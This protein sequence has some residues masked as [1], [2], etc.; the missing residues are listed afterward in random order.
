MYRYSRAGGHVTLPCNTVLGPACSTV[1]WVYHR[2]TLSPTVFIVSNGK[3]LDLGFRRNSDCSLTVLRVSEEHSGRFICSLGISAKT[4]THVYLSVLTV[5]PSPPVSAQHGSIRLLCALRRYSELSCFDGT[6]H[7]LDQD[8]KDLSGTTQSC[9]SSVR[10]DL[11]SPRSRTFTCQYQDRGEVLVF[12]E[13]S[14]RSVQPH[15]GEIL[16]DMTTQSTTTRRNVVESETTEV[17]PQAVYSYKF[18]RAG[19][20]V[21]LSCDRLKHQGPSCSSVDWLY[22]KDGSKSDIK[23][24]KGQSED[25]RLRMNSNCSVTVQNV[26]AEDAGLFRCR[27]SGRQDSD[28]VVF[29]SVLTVSR[30]P[31]DPNQN[32]I[33]LQCKLWRNSR[34]DCSGGG[35]YWLDQDKKILSVRENV[36]ESSLMVDLQKTHSRNLTCQYHDQGWRL[37]LVSAEF[38]LKSE[39]V[40]NPTT[41]PGKA[42]DTLCYMCRTDQTNTAS[43]HHSVAVLV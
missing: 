20:D 6:F 23:V 42:P 36:C 10:V 28:T 31:P 29:L 2:T 30:S 26:S 43:A 12:A 14:L 9:E 33:T 8:R 25:P 34:H 27:L 4:E 11:Q 15:G 21:T 32:N 35:F 16:T 37:L 5:C 38:N 1:D 7:W 17:S 41:A 24:S 18:F 13:Y 22:D 19:E 39:R 3:S 40:T